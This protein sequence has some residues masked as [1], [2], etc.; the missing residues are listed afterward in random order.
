MCLL[1]KFGIKTYFSQSDVIY[2]VITKWVLIL[3]KWIYKGWNNFMSDK[4]TKIYF[5]NQLGKTTSN[6]I[7]FK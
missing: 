4:I 5:L 7:F 1:I 6:P 3:W 2:Y